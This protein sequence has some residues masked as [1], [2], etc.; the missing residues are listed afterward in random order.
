LAQPGKVEVEILDLDGKRLLT[1][2]EHLKA[3]QREIAW[4]EKA[5]PPGLHLVRVRLG[6]GEAAFKM[7]VLK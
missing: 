1:A 7:P 2:R 4:D 6:G 5:L 3:G